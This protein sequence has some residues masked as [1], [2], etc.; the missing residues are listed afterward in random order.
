MSIASLVIAYMIWITSK[1]RDRYAFIEN[2]FI[3][4]LSPLYSKIDVVTLQLK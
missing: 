4:I 1:D 2:F 3:G